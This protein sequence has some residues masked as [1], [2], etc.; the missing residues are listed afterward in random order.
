MKKSNKGFT[1]IELLASV[2]I[3]GILLVFAGPRIFGMISLNRDKMYVTDAK[4]LMAQAEYKINTIHE[5]KVFYDDT[6]VIVK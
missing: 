5:D 2:V 1:L 3:L 4:K 6:L